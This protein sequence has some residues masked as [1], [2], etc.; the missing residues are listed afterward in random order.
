M[1]EGGTAVR[2]TEQDVHLQVATLQLVNMVAFESSSRAHSHRLKAVTGLDLPP[3][4]VRILEFLAGRDPLPLSRLAADLG[5]DLAQA[6]RQATALE[7]LSH[8]V[9]TTDDVDRRR[10]LVSLSAGTTT[11]MDAWLLDWSSAYLSP[12]DGW[13]SGDV[14]QLTDWFRR[15]HECLSAALPGKPTSRLS[16]R[17]QTLFPAHACDPVTRMFLSTVVDLVVW[18]GRS[19]GFNDLLRALRTPLR[20]HGYFT[21]RVVSQRGPLAVADV[22]EH[23]AIDPSQASK[24]LSQLSQLGM[25]DRAVDT[26]DRRSS[27]VRLSR[28]GVALERRVQTWQLQQFIAL[29]GEID[30]REMARLVP[31]MNRYLREL[32]HVAVASSRWTSIAGEPLFSA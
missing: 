12:L 26:F 1:R 27:L 7:V 24:R 22:A 16:E 17:G 29:L 13:S 32:E 4:D 20:Q 31:L 15:V 3:S 25:V 5:V 18:V 10:T 6:S 2:T 11:L 30:D 19:G 28:K 8:V 23:L 14:E 9:R 21:L